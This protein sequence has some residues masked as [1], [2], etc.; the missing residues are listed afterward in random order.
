MISNIVVITNIATLPFR[1]ILRLST[2]MPN[3]TLGCDTS[4]LADEWSTRIVPTLVSN[5]GTIHVKTEPFVVGEPNI[6]GSHNGDIFEQR[7]GS[8]L[9]DSIC[10]GMKSIRWFE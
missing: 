8:R 1:P 5:N 10:V 2:R 6:D 7:L 9:G 4:I 3:T